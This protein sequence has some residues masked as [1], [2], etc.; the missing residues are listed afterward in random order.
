MSKRYGYI[1]V[2][3]DDLGHGIR[4]DIKKIHFSGTRKSLKQMGMR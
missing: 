4:E 3:Q 1:Y 2:D